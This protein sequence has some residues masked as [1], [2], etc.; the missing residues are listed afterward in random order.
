MIKVFIIWLI[1]FFWKSGSTLT[2]KFDSTV[3]AK[4]FK[5]FRSGHKAEVLLG[6]KTM[7]SILFSF[8]FKKCHSLIKELLSLLLSGTSSWESSAYR[9]KEIPCF[10][11]IER[12]GRRYKVKSRGPGIELWGMPHIHWHVEE[13]LEPPRLTLSMEKLLQSEYE[14]FQN[15]V[16]FAN[17]LSRNKQ[18]YHSVRP[19]ASKNPFVFVRDLWEEV[20]ACCCPPAGSLAALI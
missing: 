18:M 10:I 1:C 7:T 20:A 17:A 5:G 2:P 13:E 12:R 11:M 19:E 16:N 8:K 15:R 4:T 14:I 9:W 6:L 3:L